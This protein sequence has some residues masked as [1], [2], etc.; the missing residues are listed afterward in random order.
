MVKSIIIIYFY[1]Y[2]LSFMISVIRLWVYHRYAGV[3]N[4]ASGVPLARPPKLPVDGPEHSFIPYEPGDMDTQAS[5]SFEALLSF[6][7]FANSSI[8]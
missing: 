1:F 4:A 6:V 5:L 8:N 7:N 2:K 3:A